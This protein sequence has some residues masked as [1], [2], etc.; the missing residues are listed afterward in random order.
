MLP[1]PSLIDATVNSAIDAMWKIIQPDDANTNDSHIFDDISSNNDH[2][3][4]RPVIPVSR[5]SNEPI[6]EWTDNDKLLSGAFPD[7]FILGQGVLKGLLSERNWKHFAKYYGGR[8]DD[9]LFI[10]HG[11]NQLQRAACI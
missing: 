7:K 10:A 9:P 1:K 2:S 4:Y 8:F 11:F 3:S 5:E 6:V